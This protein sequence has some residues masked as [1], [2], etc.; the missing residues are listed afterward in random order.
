M[1]EKLS[2]GTEETTRS[3][4]ELQKA[5]MVTDSNAPDNTRFIT[6]EELNFLLGEDFVQLNIAGGRSNYQFCKIRHALITQTKYPEYRKCMIFRVEEG[7]ESNDVV[8]VHTSLVENIDKTKKEIEAVIP[9]VKIQSAEK[10]QVKQ[11]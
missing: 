9:Q 3:L 5:A 1:S 7:M 6:R 10:S 4:E 8:L 2:A 11:Y